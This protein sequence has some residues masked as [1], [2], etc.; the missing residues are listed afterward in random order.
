MTHVWQP[1]A[2][3]PFSA[4]SPVERA[5]F[6]R[7]DFASLRDAAG[8]AIAARVFAGARERPGSV[9]DERSRLGLG[10]LATKS[11][12]AM[13]KGTI[14][15]DLA[16]RPYYATHATTPTIGAADGSVTD[17]GDADGHTAGKSFPDAA[18]SWITFQFIVP[19][20]LDTTKAVALIVHGRLGGAPSA[21]DKVEI[22]I[23][24]RAVTRDEPLLSGGATDTVTGSTTVTGYSSGDDFFVTISAAIA[25]NTLAA[26]DLVKGVIFRDGT[27]G[28]AGDTF[29][30]SVVALHAMFE[31]E[32]SAI[33]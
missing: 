12:L 7:R 26:Y 33:S 17:T 31:Y 13:P 14:Q 32:R 6:A 20:D 10:G 24:Y 3:D 2:G 4:G 29:A 19:S 15:I 16:H 22:G 27:A 11:S 28:N 5:V 23:T 1:R 21:G 9:V 8:D 30:N 18:I 25:A